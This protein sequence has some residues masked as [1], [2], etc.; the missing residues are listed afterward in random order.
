MAYFGNWLVSRRLKRSI[1]DPVGLGLLEMFAGFLFVV[2][3]VRSTPQA[4]NRWLRLA[5]ILM[6]I[7]GIV[8][9][10]VRQFQK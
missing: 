5:P 9:G 6:G 7:A 8:V 4:D 2:L 3:V 10:Y 1:I